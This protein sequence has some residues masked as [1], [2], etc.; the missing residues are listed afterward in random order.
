MAADQLDIVIRMARERRDEAAQRLA[1]AQSLVQGAVEQLQQL[2]DYQGQYI[3][4][5][6]TTAS[7]GVSVQALADAR[8]FIGEL[9][10]L[11]LAQQ[12]AVTARER[13]AEAMSQHWSEAM[14][15]LQAVEKLKA[16]RDAEATRKAIKR[17][18]RLM[19]DAYAQ[20]HRRRLT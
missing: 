7:R 20:Q 4:Q 12:S 15:Y 1:D 17:E 18:Q 2:R 8:K 5:S 10:S 13:D 6:E 14:G 16:I 9:D 3:Q 19:D 11:I